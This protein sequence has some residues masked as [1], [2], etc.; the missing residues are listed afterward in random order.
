MR[1]RSERV[2]VSM[3]SNYTHMC[4]RQGKYRIRRIEGLHACLRLFG[5]YDARDRLSKRNTR[6][7]IESAMDVY[8]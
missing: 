1:N 8:I 3:R 6:W 7:M 4:D 5:I 2:A